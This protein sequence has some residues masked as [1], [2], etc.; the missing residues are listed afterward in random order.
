V[1]VVLV[2]AL[3]VYFALV[4]QARTTLL[5]S[6][7]LAAEMVVKLTAVS[8]M[9][10][11]V[12][13][14][15]TE[16]ERAVGDLAKNPDVQDVELWPVAESGGSPSKPIASYHREEGGVD[17]ET[18]PATTAYRR[19]SMAGV[20]V[21]EPVVDPTDK[22]IAVLTVHFSMDREAETLASLARDSLLAA[23]AAAVVLALG[24]LLAI[25]RVAVAPLRRLQSSAR[26]LEQGSGDQDRL[27]PLR[28]VFRDEATQLTEAFANMA[29]AV[30][31][32]EE[33][34]ALR[35]ADLKLILD[36]VDQGFVTARADG[37]LL[38]EHSAVLDT[39]LGEMP[40]NST[41]WAL[42]GRIDERVGSWVEAGW[43]QLEDDL[44]PV[45]VSLAQ[46]PQRVGREGQVFSIAYHAVVEEGELC[47]VV[48]VLS[49][50]T[51]EVERERARQAQQEYSVL[52]D[53]FTEDRRA[54]IDFW[55]ETSAL[56]ET[57][58]ANTVGELGVLKRALHTLKGTSR[59]FGLSRI[60]SLA[61][62]L[63]DA[64]AEHGRLVEGDAQRLSEAWDGLAQ[65]VEPLLRDATQSLRLTREEYQ[66]LRDAIAKKRPHGELARIVEEFQDEPTERRLLRAKELLE[67]T[68]R[69]LDKPI[70]RVVIAHNGVRLRPEPWVTFWS[71]LP[72][73]LN[74]AADHGLE[75][76]AE[77]EAAGKPA[78]ST[79]RLETTITNGRLTVVVADDGRGIDWER[80]RSR[81]EASGLP[82]ES[83]QDLVAALFKDGVSTKYEVSEVSGR[84]VGL[85]A[86][87][88]AVEQLGGS[89]A[90]QSKTGV[91]TTWRFSFP[92]QNG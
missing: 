20:L 66:S 26:R 62:D 16:I 83:E 88:G 27:A 59:F 23:L 25:S 84:G 29:T 56:I 54:F 72:L 17:S 38:A 60:S 76:Q 43:K 58:L 57:I 91:G 92:V 44:L 82:S 5:Q 14:D 39:W 75:T 15:E 81:A 49:D 19:A 69:K 71:V 18:A 77:R 90:V 21:T 55:N 3:A 8:V 80:V 70:P 64:V 28:S 67:A 63:E 87:K 6:K 48:V 46:L 78:P 4:R 32:R 31:D 40:G 22:A 41:I 50:V 74:N 33:R 42:I 35:N 24:L 68:C 9:P 36:S 12:F 47:Q 73:L 1:L 11:I 86:V 53:R 52:V 30:A 7:E 45:E 10:A 61:H 37:R 2:V 89:V 65:R 85:G 34:L 51:A 13:G 79:V